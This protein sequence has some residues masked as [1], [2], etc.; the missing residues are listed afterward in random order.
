MAGKRFLGKIVSSHCE[1]RG[2]QNFHQSALSGAIS[3]INVFL[4]FTQKFK[5]AAKLAGK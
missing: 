5:M 3:E 4:H 1:Y 2:G